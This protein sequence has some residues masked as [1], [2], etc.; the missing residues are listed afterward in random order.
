MSDLDAIAASMIIPPA[1]VAENEAAGNAAERRREQREREYQ[2]TM[3]AKNEERRRAQPAATDTS[4]EGDAER[5]DEPLTGTA[6][7]PS[8]QSGGAAPDDADDYDGDGVDDDA[9][10]PSDQGQDEDDVLDLA[11]GYAADHERDEDTGDDTAIDTSKLGDDVKLSVTVDGEEREVTLGDLK[12]RY[13]GEGAIESRLQAATEARKQAL[14]DY[15][16]SSGLMK[17]VLTNFGQMMFRRTVP[18]PTPQ[19]AEQNPAAFL[20]QKQMFDDETAAIQTAQQQLYQMTM[21]VDQMHQQN[22]QARRQQA[23]QELRRIMP[24]FNDPVNGPK[25]RDALIDTARKIGYTD[26]QIAACDDPLLYKTMAYAA[27]EIRRMEAVTV[28]KSKS[29]PRAMKKT[30]TGAQKDSAAKRQAEAMQRAK[31]TGSVDDVAATMIV[32]PQRKTRSM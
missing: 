17:E 11:L 15:E 30:G 13:A 24:V 14:D 18:E 1:K 26:E 2:R 8:E 28:D 5:E 12:R 7:R 9:D 32:A 22:Q 20:K 3:V 29:K 19:L 16:R 21:Q 4:P 25:V 27:R 23:A 6:S 10:A 31:R